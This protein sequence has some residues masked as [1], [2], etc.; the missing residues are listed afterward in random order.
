[1]RF[2]LIAAAI[3]AAVPAFAADDAPVTEPTVAYP[4]VTE[5]EFG[6]VSVEAGLIRPEMKLSAEAR[7][8]TFPSMID[9]REDFSTEMDQSV[10][11]VR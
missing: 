3:C 5:V 11:Y 10:R 6:E 1:M 7:R 8:L 2:L 4:K 9:L